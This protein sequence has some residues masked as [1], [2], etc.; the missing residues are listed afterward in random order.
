MAMPLSRR[1]QQEGGGA[2]E[3]MRDADAAAGLLP[4]G[5][6]LGHGGRWLAPWER[7]SPNHTPAQLPGTWD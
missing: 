6:H 2:R 3:R 5:S 7:R 1:G 4:D